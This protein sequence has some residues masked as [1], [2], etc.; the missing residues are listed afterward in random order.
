MR[1]T[2]LDLGARQLG[3]GFPCFALASVGPAH[4]GSGD[5]AVRMIEA[6]F[7]M[8]ADGIAFQVFRADLLVVR[9]HP[10]RQGLDAIELSEEQWRRV[11]TAARTSGLAV[12]A[13]V[14]DRP[15][16]DVAAEAGVDALEVHA[17]DMEN[18]DLIR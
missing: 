13:Q 2:V 1:P 7:K 16:L 10:E 17:T 18:P 15:S 3:P 11:L 6:A 9:R 14:F 4:G 8:G 12:V 5:T